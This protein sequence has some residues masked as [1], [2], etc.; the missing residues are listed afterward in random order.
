MSGNYQSGDHC[1]NCTFFEESW[2]EP[3]TAGN[4]HRNPPGAHVA[5]H[6]APGFKPRMYCG[7]PTVHPLDFCGEF[8]PRKGVRK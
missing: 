6:A 2:D 1:Y 5:A 8:S 3:D 7:F 4:C